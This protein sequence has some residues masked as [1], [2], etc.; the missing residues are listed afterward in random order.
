MGEDGAGKKGISPGKTHSSGRK[1][2][3]TLASEEGK[4]SWSA[5]LL[6]QGKLL[7]GGLP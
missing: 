7:K 3:D 2:G 4:A 1:G 6:R 5:R